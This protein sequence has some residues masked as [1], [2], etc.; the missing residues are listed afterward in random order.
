MLA[1]IGR[2]ARKEMLRR[3][4]ASPNMHQHPTDR[5]RDRTPIQ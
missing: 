2:D 4:G 5:D 1:S 3:P